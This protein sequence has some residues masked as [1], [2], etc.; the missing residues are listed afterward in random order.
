MDATTTVRVL[1]AVV[2]PASR[3][4]GQDRDRTGAQAPAAGRTTRDGI[5]GVRNLAAGHGQSA[6]YDRTGM[7]NTDSLCSR[8]RGVRIH[9]FC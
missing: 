9:S 1:A 8:A 4:G 6:G 2:L 7:R 3:V 5:L